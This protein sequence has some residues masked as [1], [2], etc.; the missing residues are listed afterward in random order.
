MKSPGKTA[1]AFRFY[2][3]ISKPAIRHLTLCNNYAAFASTFTLLAI[4]LSLRSASSSSL[5]V[6]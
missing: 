2:A 3:N 6:C 4:W 1:R 5:K